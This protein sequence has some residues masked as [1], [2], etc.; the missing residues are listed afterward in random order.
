MTNIHGKAAVIYLGAAGAAAINIGEQLDWA[1][2][3]D[4]ATVDTTPLV[5]TWK[6]FVKG[7][8]GWTG[9]IAGNFDVA[10]TQVWLAS[11]SAVVE[12]F[13]LYPQVSVPTSYYYGTVWVQMTKIAAGSTTA[14][15]SGGFK[16]TGHNA[17]SFNG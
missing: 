3:F 12:K 1:L 4:M 9:V 2:D 17:L 16:V 6:Q 14:K 7:M 8:M 13:Y 10:S 11:V 15:A 5:N